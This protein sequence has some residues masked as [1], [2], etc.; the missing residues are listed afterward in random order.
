MIL[1]MNT[2]H[3]CNAH[4]YEKLKFLYSSFVHENEIK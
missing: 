2:S 4:E 3:F 1:R